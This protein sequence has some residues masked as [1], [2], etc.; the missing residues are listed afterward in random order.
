MTEALE[1]YTRVTERA[2]EP[3]KLAEGW[4]GRAESLFRL[5]RFA[6]AIAAYDRVLELNPAS[7]FALNNR[8]A[9][10]ESLGLYEAAL[11][12]YEQALRLR[13]DDPTV[14]GNR[15]RVLRLLEGG[16]D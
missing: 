10:R 12:D 7:V 16:G 4:L 8:G 14:R 9:A 6:E 15:D 13:P 11:Q 5:L 1:Y 2:Q 3:W